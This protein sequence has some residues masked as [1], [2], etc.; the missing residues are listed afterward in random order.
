M[1]LTH[2]ISYV[3]KLICMHNM[4]DLKAKDFLIKTSN[5]E[6][7]LIPVLTIRSIVLS[8]IVYK[9]ILLNFLMG[10]YLIN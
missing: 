10:D 4:I 6:K 5:T 7:F 9:Y 1:H 3:S 8:S 2:S